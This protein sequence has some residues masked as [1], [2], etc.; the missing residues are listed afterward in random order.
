MRQW[1]LPTVEKII[2]YLSTISQG[3]HQGITEHP[4]FFNAG[5]SFPVSTYLEKIFRTK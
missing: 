4:I 2:I 1:D 5:K 3:R